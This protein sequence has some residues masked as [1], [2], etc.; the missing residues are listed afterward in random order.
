MTYY[1]MTRMGVA[2]VGLLG[3]S[4]YAYM[5]FAAPNNTSNNA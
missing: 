5:W 3:I 4:L 1:Y 2:G